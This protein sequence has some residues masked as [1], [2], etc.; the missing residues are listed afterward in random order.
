M[1]HRR[2]PVEPARSPVRRLIFGASMTR[3]LPASRYMTHEEFLAFYSFG[4]PALTDE[5]KRASDLQT[6]QEL[7]EAGIPWLLD[8][9]ETP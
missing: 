6:A 7:Q 1:Q 3:P 8:P 2:L 5:D 4:L 9:I